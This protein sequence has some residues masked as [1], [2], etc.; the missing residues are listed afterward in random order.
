MQLTRTDAGVST[1]DRR[2]WPVVALS[3]GLA[4]ASAMTACSDDDGSSVAVDN[5]A[6]RA[7][8][9]VAPELEGQA[10]ETVQVTLEDYQFA[11]ADLAAPAGI[12]TFSALNQGSEN[13]ELAFLPG[14][15]EVPLTTAGAPDE[16]ALEAL[17]A[18]ELEA[19]GPGQSCNATYQLGVG[20]YT[21]FCIVEAPDG[22]THLSKGM[23]GTLTVA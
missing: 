12:V 2:R 15:G 20:T 1:H 18:F 3:V 9:P 23:K 13:H 6:N 5:A 16:E 21:L 10:V 7:C 19:F 22:T 8:E 11:P 17:G 4:L 14:G